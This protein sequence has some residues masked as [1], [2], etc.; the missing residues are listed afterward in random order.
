M[1]SVISK[2][3]MQFIAAQIFEAIYTIF[4]RRLHY[5]E[6][7]RNSFIFSRYSFIVSFL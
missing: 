3:S 7:L 5:E 6:H 4:K 1:P 2:K